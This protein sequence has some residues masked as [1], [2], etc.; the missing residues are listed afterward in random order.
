LPLDYKSFVKSLTTALFWTIAN[1]KHH[2]FS[3]VH[4]H[5]YKF[6]STLL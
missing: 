6:E 4:K 1:W 5:S 3:V 2:F